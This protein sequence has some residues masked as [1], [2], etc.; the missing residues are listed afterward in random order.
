MDTGTLLNHREFWGSEEK[1]EGRELH[2]LTPQEQ[3]VY[4]ALLANTHAERLRLEQERVRYDDLLAALRRP[5]E[6]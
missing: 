6:G 4:Q 2:R 3:E 1:P 5:G